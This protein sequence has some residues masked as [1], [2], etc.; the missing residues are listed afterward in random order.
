MTGPATRVI[1][2][3]PDSQLRMTFYPGI[4]AAGGL[5]LRLFR[6]SPAEESTED[7]YL[8]TAAGLVIP[9]EQL[10]EFIGVVSEVAAELDR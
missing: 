1:P 7:A 4:G 9:R 10:A 3:D 8:P 2:R 5:E 6:K